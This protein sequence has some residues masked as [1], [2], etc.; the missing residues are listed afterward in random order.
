M[1]L[2]TFVNCYLSSIQQGIQTG[3]ILGEIVNKYQVYSCTRPK[4]VYNF[5]RVHKTFIVCNAGN[6]YGVMDYVGLFDR[7]ENP[8]PWS[9]FKED[10]QSLAGLITGVGIILPKEV[11]AAKLGEDGLY[12]YE[13]EEENTSITYNSGSWMEELIRSVKSAPLAR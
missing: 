1:R 11:Y 12:R 9:Y 3:H 2:Y 7:I 8:F 4:Q 13:N 6:F 10:Q 5:L